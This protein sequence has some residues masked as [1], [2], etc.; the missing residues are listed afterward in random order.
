MGWARYRRPRRL[1]Y[2]RGAAI[3]GVRLST[4]KAVVEPAARMLVRRSMRIPIVKPRS[5]A[6]FFDSGLSRPVRDPTSSQ[7]PGGAGIGVVR[8]LQ[9]K[10]EPD[11]ALAF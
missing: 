6:C 8:R 4:A 5:I 1:R 10:K 7:N 3:V 2:H 11:H 9:I